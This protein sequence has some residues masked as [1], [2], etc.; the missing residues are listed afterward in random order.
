[1]ATQAIAPQVPA[2]RKARGRRDDRRH[3]PANKKKNNINKNNTKSQRWK[4]CPICGSK[5]H[6]VPS[7]RLRSSLWFPAPVL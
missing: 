6:M 2:L 7:H 3:N 4:F 1:M 5:D